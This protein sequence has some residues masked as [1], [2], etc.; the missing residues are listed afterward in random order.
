MPL[1]AAPRRIRIRVV[2]LPGLLDLLLVLVLQP[3]GQI[4]HERV[5]LAKLACHSVQPNQTA[6][7]V[8]GAAAAWAGLVA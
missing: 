4:A 3:G 2:W 5:A 8:F 7:L 1:P 6:A